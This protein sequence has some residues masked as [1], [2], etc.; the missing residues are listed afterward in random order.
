MN[1]REWTSRLEQAVPEVPSVFHNAMLSAFA[2]IQEQEEQHGSGT[3]V[4]IQRPKLRKRTAAIIL[5]AAL[6]MASVALAAAFVVP[7]VI[8]VFFG[9]DVAM[10]EDLTEL[11]QSDVVEMM[12]G[13]CRVRLEEALYDGVT[14]YTTFSVRNMNVDRM[15]GESFPDDP[16]GSTRYLTLEEA[17]TEIYTWD[18]Y[19]WRDAIWIDGQEIR[20]STG[21]FQL[22]GGDEPGEYLYYQINRLDQENVEISGHPRITLPI[23]YDLRREYE[24][25]WIPPDENGDIP[26]PEGNA[27]MTFYVDADIVDLVRIKDGPVTV[28]TDGT[29]VQ[30]KQAVFTPFRLYVALQ[31]TISE[32]LRQ[33]YPEGTEDHTIA[34]LSCWDMMLIDGEGQPIERDVRD[35]IDFSDGDKD[36]CYLEFHYMDEYPSPLYM[37]PVIDGITD[38]T[39]RVL[40]RE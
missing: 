17:E 9:K 33:Q 40:I 13:D 26:E 10:R 6:L 21:T 35:G 38:M 25:E 20:T 19:L 4:E 37:A 27:A 11:A 22:I 18:A 36:L 5:I 31:F 16:L 28:W 39:R 30:V 1:E 7:G 3:V 14:L 29:Q 8:G 34:F 32:E 2:Q 24:N 12:V 23:G 15:M